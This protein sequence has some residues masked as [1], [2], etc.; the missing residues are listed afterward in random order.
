[1]ILSHD[2]IIYGRSKEA[3]TKLLK[4]FRRDG[5]KQVK[6][7][8]VSHPNKESRPPLDATIRSKSAAAKKAQ[9][10]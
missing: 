8:D 1:M 5:S 3:F 2:Q 4:D 6:G 9:V 7:E 10:G